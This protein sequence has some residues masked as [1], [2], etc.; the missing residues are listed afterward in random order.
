MKES[1]SAVRMPL[2]NSGIALGT[3]TSHNMRSRFAPML[4]ADQ[5]STCSLERAPLNAPSVTVS[6][7]PR[8]MSGI[9][10]LLLNPS[11]S[12]VIGHRAEF[13]IGYNIYTNALSTT[14]TG[15]LLA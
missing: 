8:K 5:T 1:A 7:P 12:T 10:G 14:L 15:R 2:S 6:L 4:R 9:L 13:G 3:T 11:H